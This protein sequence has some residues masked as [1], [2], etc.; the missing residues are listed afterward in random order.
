M[1]H[2]Q[3]SSTSVFQCLVHFSMPIIVVWCVVACPSHC[4]LYFCIDIYM[5]LSMQLKKKKHYWCIVGM[6][7][8]IGDCIYELDSVFFLPMSYMLS[9]MIYFTDKI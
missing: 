2:M 5:S 8:N 3:I 9:H 6:V 7:R 4:N 1:K